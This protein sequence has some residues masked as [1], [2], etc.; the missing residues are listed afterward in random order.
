VAN[1][2]DITIFV[3]RTADFPIIEEAIHQYVKASGACLNP[4]K[5]RALAV[6]K[7]SPA[8]TVLGFECHP[9]IKILGVTFWSSPEESMNDSLTRLTGRVCM[10]AKNAYNRD[11]CL[12]HRV[13]YVHT[14]LL[15]K[16]WY[17]AQS[18]PTPTRHTQKITTAIAWYIWKR[19]IF[20]VPVA[21]LQ[22][23]KNM[24]GWELVDID[25]K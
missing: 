8:E 13:R 3:A 24:V 23:Q 15:T 21:M 11:L 19:A 20:R 25:T 17:T 22:R 18:F 9:H 14:Y 2:E 12:A 1:A 4:Q 10:H 6:G 5:S 16:I 7:W